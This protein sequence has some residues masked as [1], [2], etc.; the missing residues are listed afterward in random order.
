M[1]QKQYFYTDPLAA[2]WMAKHFGMEFLDEETNPDLPYKVTYD[3]MIEGGD[4]YR[5]LRQY[6]I[7]TGSMHL[8]EARI[9]DVWQETTHAGVVTAGVVLAVDRNVITV[10]VPERHNGK[11]HF[12]CPTSLG[13]VIQRDG[14]PF[15]WPDRT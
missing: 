7:H 1:T 12:C 11:H 14:L 6:I 4:L 10:R 5:P 9:G 3:L 13:L 2:A 15:F 8:L